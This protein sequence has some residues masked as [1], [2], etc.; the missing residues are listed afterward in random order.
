MERL[1]KAQPLLGSLLLV[2]VFAAILGILRRIFGRI[3]SDLIFFAVIIYVI[4]TITG[5]ALYTLLH[6]RGFQFGG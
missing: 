2:G 3:T 4:V 6:V 1:L 5:S